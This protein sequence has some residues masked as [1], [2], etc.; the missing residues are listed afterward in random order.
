[1][2]IYSF[3]SFFSVGLRVLGTVYLKKFLL[4]AFVLNSENEFRNILEKVSLKF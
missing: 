3:W 4:P 2:P 1:M